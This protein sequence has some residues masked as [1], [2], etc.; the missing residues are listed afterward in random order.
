MTDAAFTVGQVVRITGT[1]LTGSVG[2]VVW[3]DHERDRY[4][5]RVGTA[6]PYFRADDLE[7]FRTPS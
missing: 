1:V 2:V 3:F 7:P 4:L 5:V 6:Q